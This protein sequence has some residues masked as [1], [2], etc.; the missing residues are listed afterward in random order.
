VFL[1]KIRPHCLLCREDGGALFQCDVKFG[2]VHPLC[3][4]L[5]PE[6]S[7]VRAAV[8]VCMCLCR[9]AGHFWVTSP[10]LAVPLRCW[11]HGVFAHV[12]IDGYVTG[13]ACNLEEV[14][15]PRL[16]LVR[17]VVRHCHCHSPARPI[18][19]LSCRPSLL[20]SL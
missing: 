17:V 14:V 5:L 12:Q 1:G 6:T 11:T 3:A 2:W 13:V 9:T 15:T 16:A 10:C 19:T 20:A 4:C 7:I 8:C 18:Y